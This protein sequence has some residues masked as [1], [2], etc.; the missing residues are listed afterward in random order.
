MKQ[1]PENIQAAGEY[2]DPEDESLKVNIDELLQNRNNSVF[3]T[4]PIKIKSGD[5]Q[6]QNAL[7]EEKTEQ[8]DEDEDDVLNEVFETYEDHLEHV[9]CG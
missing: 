7:E 9:L 5:I 4:L 2:D 3:K 8:E 6:I 1:L